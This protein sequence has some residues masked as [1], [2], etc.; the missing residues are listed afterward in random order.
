MKLTPQLVEGA[1][2]Q[3]IFP[4]ADP[5]GTIA[6]YQPDPRAILPLDAFHVPH[7]LRRVVKSGTYEIRRDTA[8]PEVIRACA[9]ATWDRPGTWISGDIVSVYTDLH[10]QGIAHSVEA[11][12]DDH[13][14]GGLYGVA[15]GG[16]FAGE[17][18]F[19]RARDASKAALV[20]LVN[21]LNER[22]FTLLDIQFMTEHLKQFGAIEMPARD[23]QQRLQESLRAPASWR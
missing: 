7:S 2:R 14:V 6:W 21:H 17:S 18:M 8:F 13:L 4:M 9:E 5:D 15:I 20:N 12:R 23:Y 11:W 3:G 16:F 10:Q 1:Y 19:S 22:G